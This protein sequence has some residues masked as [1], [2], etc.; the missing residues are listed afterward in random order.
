MKSLAKLIQFGCWG[1]KEGRKQR[2]K[3]LDV[4]GD[5]ILVTQR[6]QA[7]Q[8]FTQSDAPL[9]FRMMIRALP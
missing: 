1:D 7:T 6:G 8:S 4:A 3:T 5:E 2:A 9:S